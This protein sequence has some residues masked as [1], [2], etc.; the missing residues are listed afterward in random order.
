[1]WYS[2]YLD[3]RP[4][5]VNGGPSR[6]QRWCMNLIALHRATSY[7]QGLGQNGILWAQLM[8]YK[9][10]A[11][12]WSHSMGSFKPPYAGSQWPWL[13]CYWK[14]ICNSITTIHLKWAS[15]AKTHIKLREHWARLIAVQH[16]YLLV[17]FL[18]SSLSFS[19]SVRRCVWC[20]WATVGPFLCCH[21]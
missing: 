17:V 10:V 13:Y 15:P 18:M 14:G 12:N 9:T 11:H 6:H 1:M 21:Q 8:S 5:V 4:G 7:I 3:G 20:H 2:L 19:V 16:V